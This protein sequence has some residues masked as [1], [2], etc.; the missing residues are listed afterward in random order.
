MTT[1]SEGSAKAR[2]RSSAK[3]GRSSSAGST[4]ARNRPELGSSST[5]AKWAGRLAVLTSAVSASMLPP[6]EAEV[7]DASP[8]GGGRDRVV[9]ERVLVLRDK[10]PV[11]D[12]VAGP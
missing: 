5:R 12:R 6:L 4:V 8:E 10:A 3:R 2:M 7:G 11:R 9:A 1:R